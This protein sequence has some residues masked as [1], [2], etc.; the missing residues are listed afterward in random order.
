MMLSRWSSLSN[1]ANTEVKEHA[2]MEAGGFPTP[3]VHDFEN[4][5]MV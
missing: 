5:E 2:K 4:V 1:S 3:R